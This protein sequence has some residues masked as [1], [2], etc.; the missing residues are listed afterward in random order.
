MA[1][2][3][4]TLAG[5]LKEYYVGPVREQ[6]NQEANVR[7]LMKSTVVQWQGQQCVISLHTARN[8][9]EIGRAHV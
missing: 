2:T 1:A 6:I 8:T 5:I 4:T 3:T 7:S 9:G